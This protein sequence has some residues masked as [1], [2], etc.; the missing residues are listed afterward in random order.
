MDESRYG[1]T[2]RW[3]VLAVGLPPAILLFLI[4]AVLT[5]QSWGVLDGTE[6]STSLS[7]LGP[8]LA[9]LGVALGFVVVR[10]RP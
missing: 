2:P 10:R 1:R 3:K 8:L 4:G 7:I 6:E 5:V 9:G